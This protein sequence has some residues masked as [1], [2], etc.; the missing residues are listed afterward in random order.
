MLKVANLCAHY[1]GIEALRGIDISVASGEIVT[2]IGPNGA[3]KSTLLNCLSGLVH[4]LSGSILF[5][6]KEIARRAPYAI[7]R[8]G[9]LQVPE[10]RQILGEL[11]VIENLQL[12]LLAANKRPATHDLAAVFALFP[13]LEQKMN[14]KGASLSGGQQQMLAIGRALMGAPRLLLLDEPSLGLSPLLTKQVFDALKLLNS[15]GVTILLVEQNAKRALGISHRAYIL[16][17][18][19]IVHEGESRAAMADPRVISYYLGAAVH[20]N[21]AS[22]PAAGLNG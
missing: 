7:S 1:S 12:G 20:E 18:G 10:G 14:D 4:S 8:R 16:E 11:T 17:R 6:G 21:D 22:Q 13:V 5:E 19:R 9:L 2:I 15:E 3:G